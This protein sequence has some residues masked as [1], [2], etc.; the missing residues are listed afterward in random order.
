[1]SNDWSTLS[2]ERGPRRFALGWM[3]WTVIAVLFFVA[4]FSALWWGGV[5][6]SGAVGSGQLHKDQQSA[7]NREQWSAT[8]NGDMNNLLADRDNIDV[9]KQTV[10]SPGATAK[11]LTDLQGAQLNCN[12]DIAKY[13]QDAANVLGA[14]WLPAGFPAQVNSV[15]YCN[16]SNQ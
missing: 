7:S 16:G 9:L 11:D 10:H 5:F 15:T 1:M 4:L 13:N 3:G 6:A 2:G 8:Y 14:Q 12:Q